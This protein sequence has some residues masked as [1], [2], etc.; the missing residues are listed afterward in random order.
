M[1]QVILKG[2][3]MG[4]NPK[5]TSWE[6]KE[7]TAVYID[8]YQPES[9]ESEKTVQVKADDLAILQTLNKDFAM[10]SV[11]ECLAS[12]SGYKNKVYYKFIKLVG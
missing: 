12:S 8:L 6:G 4:A 3:F 5:T 2:M 7:K 9:P 10:G 11:F 1:A